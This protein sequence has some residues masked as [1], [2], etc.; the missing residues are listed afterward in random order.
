[1]IEH[2]LMPA[3]LG[4]KQTVIGCDPIGGMV[5]GTVGLGGVW[6]KKSPQLAPLSDSEVMVNG[7]VH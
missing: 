6:I 4:R 5:N 3:A 1:M 2:V 7:T